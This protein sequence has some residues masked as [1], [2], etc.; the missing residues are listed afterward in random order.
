MTKL[1]LFTGIQQLNGRLE[2]CAQEIV[3][4]Q[5]QQKEHGN[6]L[7][8]IKWLQDTKYN[9]EYLF[10]S[11]S[12]DSF[13][14]WEAYVSWLKILLISLGISHSDVA[15]HFRIMLEVLKQEL[16]EDFHP[17]LQRYL[18]RAILHFS[19]PNFQKA[20]ALD[21]T[22][23]YYE[24]AKRY[25]MLLLASKKQE[26]GEYIKSLIRNPYTVKDIYLNVLQPV[27]HE[28]GNLWHNQQI[29]VAQ[30][31]YCTGITQYIISQMYPYIFSAT[32]KK[33]KMISTCVSGELHEIGLR[34]V[35]DILEMEG[36][37]TMYLGANMPEKDVVQTAFQQKAE[38][39]AI[40][41]TLPIHLHKAEALIAAMRKNP[42][43]KNIKLIVGGY[44][45]VLDPT[46]WQKIGA[47]AFAKDA[48]DVNDVATKLVENCA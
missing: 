19:H 18:D 29:S 14:L 44:P 15:D 22:S 20:T 48:S 46:L 42:L 47:D 23:P 10:E 4:K 28:I 35:T 26:A 40:S 45:F 33:H 21:P 3:H 39:L 41:V 7:L 9:L 43:T 2:G 27:Q 6:E 16:P 1:K 31:H 5:W 32:P 17:T 25:Q 34:M 36:W 12:V 38:L 8:K 24:K 11:M 37:D 13:P 30:E